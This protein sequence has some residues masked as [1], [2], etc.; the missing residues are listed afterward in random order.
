MLKN[1]K[2]EFNLQ[3]SKSSKKE[4]P[5]FKARPTVAVTEMELPKSPNEPDED[6]SSSSPEWAETMDAARHWGGASYL[7]SRR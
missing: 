5:I 7:P 4:V 6:N 1:C 2:A 3:L